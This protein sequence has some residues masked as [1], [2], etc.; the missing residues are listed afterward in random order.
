MLWLLATCP[1]GAQ[2]VTEYAPIDSLKAGDTFTYTITL[3]K[4]RN[5]D[6]VQFPDS[7]HFG[8]SLEI[9]SR[10]HFRVTDFKDSLVYTLQFF[11]TEDTRIDDLPV[12]MLSGSDT[13]TVYTTPV[14][15]RFKSV[16]QD[17]EEQFRPL[18]PIFEFARAIWPYLVG[19]LVLGILGWY[20]YRWYRQ[21][22]KQPE[23]KPRPAFQA[24]PFKNPLHQLEQSLNELK[25]FTFET[26]QDFELFYIRLGDAIRTYFEELYRIPALESTS[27]EI[28]RELES[29]VV[30][31][32]LIDQTRNVLREADMVKFA[33]FQPTVEQTEESLSIA[34]DFLKVAR[35]NDGPRVELMRRRHQTRMDEER[36]RY[37]EETQLP[38]SETENR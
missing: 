26:E 10:Q 30:D 3:N 13:T 36:R 12:R 31:E 38:E 23:Q 25:S 32:R 14:S 9:R 16:L 7:S 4:D 35:K 29:R 37:E 34:N 28:I 17:E 6:Q 33:K 2:N 19:L 21:S 1:A 8:P 20:L 11:G 5:Y 24:T 22:P 15:L 18:K 27:R